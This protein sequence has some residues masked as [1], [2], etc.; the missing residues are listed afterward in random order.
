[1]NHSIWQTTGVYLPQ[2][3]PVHNL[4]HGPLWST[5]VHSGLLHASFNCIFTLCTWLT[6]AHGSI[7]FTFHYNSWCTPVLRSTP[8]TF[9]GA[10]S[11]PAHGAQSTAVY[12]P[13]LS[14]VISVP[15]P[16]Q[17]TLHSIPVHLLQP[18]CTLVHSLIHYLLQST[19]HSS[20]W[21]TFHGL[22][23]FIV[24]FRIW[25]TTVQR[26]LLFTIH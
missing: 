16:F 14:M 21:C 1:M 20:P 4:F 23:Q 13:F 26:P 7:Q 3:T 18:W 5:W 15:V 11:T 9:Y 17:S 25:C 2:S 10:W 22:F 12:S 8:A 19:V 24:H 6:P